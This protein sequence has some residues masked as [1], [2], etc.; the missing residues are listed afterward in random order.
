LEDSLAS[1]ESRI[2]LRQ[3]L[4]SLFSSKAVQAVGWML[5]SCIALSVLSGLGRMLGQLD[6]N[7]LQT[8]FCRIVFAFIVMLPFVVHQG[9]HTVTTAQFKIYLLRS[10]SGMIAMWTWF[11]AVTLIPIGEQ[12]ALSFLAPLFTTMGAALV[13]GEVVRARRWVAIFVGFA[14]AL[15]IIR[16]GIIEISTG[17]YVAILSAL[18]MGCSALIIKR[19]TRQD[20]PL[21][22]VFISHMIMMPISIIPALLVWQWYSYDIWL[23]LFATGPIAA[24]G[25]FTLTKA[26]SLAD[27]S[28]VAGID[29]VRLPI[30]VLIG[31]ILFSELSDIWTWVGASIIF[32]S[33]IYVIRREMSIHSTAVSK[34]AELIQKGG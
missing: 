27:A 30:A 9:L 14:G 4:A 28:F 10:V 16:P 3:K 13:L 32:A 18:A 15:I 33:S 17:H 2:D 7:P 29:Y 21:I 23:I 11:Y 1:L 6:V 5:I 8:V 34:S 12:T 19:L 26:F 24:I 31:W 20:N 25:H 22:I